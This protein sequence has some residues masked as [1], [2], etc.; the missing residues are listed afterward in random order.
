MNLANY[1]SLSLHSL[2]SLPLREVIGNSGLLRARNPMPSHGSPA[3]EGIQIGSRQSNVDKLI[4]LLHAY[5]K[6][7][8]YQ[9]QRFP[10]YRLGFTYTNNYFS[11]NCRPHLTSH[12]VS[13]RVG[14]QIC[15][16]LPQ[17]SLFIYNVIIM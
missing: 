11:P 15:F 10:K 13:L 4:S 17:M 7:E 6:N 9:T 2:D 1:R 12:P 14:P 5:E 8:V 3:L 16:L